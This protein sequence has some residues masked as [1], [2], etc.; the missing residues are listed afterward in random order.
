MF[1]WRVF[2]SPLNYK[3]LFTDLDK[4]IL[5]K[6]GFRLDSIFTTAQIATKNGTW[7]K[8]GQK[9]LENNHLTSLVKIRETSFQHS[10]MF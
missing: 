10:W 1:I 8:N 5:I 9:Q 6:I 2:L 4:L 3:E 7:L